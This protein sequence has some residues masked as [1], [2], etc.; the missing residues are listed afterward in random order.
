ME[1]GGELTAHITSGAVI[2]YAIEFLK[3][4]PSFRWLT[5]DTKSLSR[6]VS[7]IAAAAMA[8]G[9]T[10]T[11]DWQ[12]GGTFH[13]PGGMVLLA[14]AYD[15]LKQFVLQQ[16]IFDSVVNKQKIAMQLPSSLP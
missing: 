6:I 12:A 3:S 8:I 13:V 1:S 10:G 5:T 2:V 16:L 7:A 11:Y 14:G 4:Q 15:W 9:I